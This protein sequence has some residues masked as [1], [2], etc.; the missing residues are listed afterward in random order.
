MITTH[1]INDINNVEYGVGWNRN[2]GIHEG[3][4]C[5]VG[6]IAYINFTASPVRKG[7]WSQWGITVDA[8]YPFVWFSV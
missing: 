4:K 5:K 7:Q 2:I 6:V 1:P 8:L 3:Q